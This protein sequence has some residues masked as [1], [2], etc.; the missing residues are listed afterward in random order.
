MGGAMAR[1]RM[2]GRRIR[3]VRFAR[4]VVVS[5]I[6]ALSIALVISALP[7]L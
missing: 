7:P 4:I 3:R 5:I 6:V 2:R 1:A